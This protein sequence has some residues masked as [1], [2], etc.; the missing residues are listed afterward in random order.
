MVEITDFNMETKYEDFKSNEIEDVYPKAGECLLEFLH[1]CKLRIRKLCCAQGAILFFI[2]RAT[3]KVESAQH[4]KRKEN[5][6]RNKPEFYFDNRGV[7][8]KKEK[9]PNHQRGKPCSCMIALNSPQGRWSRPV[10]KERSR[11]QRWRNVKT[12][13]DSSITYRENFQVSERYSYGT[14]NYK[15]KNMMSSNQLRRFQRKKKAEKE[16]V[17]SSNNKSYQSRVS[18]QTK[19]PVVRQLFSPKQVKSKGKEKVEVPSEEDE[20]VIDN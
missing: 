9:F 7:L 16:A 20:L 10:G 1:R 4:A 13:R 8:I 5:W 18:D 17:E 15:G 11:N 3:K 14:N 6:R 2:K 19:K 12:G